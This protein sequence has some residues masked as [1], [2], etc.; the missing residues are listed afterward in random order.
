MRYRYRIERWLSS[1]HHS[2]R[3]CSS[4]D[5]EPL[6]SGPIIGPSF[7]FEQPYT[8]STS[9]TSYFDRATT[10]PSTSQCGSL[11]PSAAASAARLIP[12]YGAPN[13]ELHLPNT[14]S[15]P[16]SPSVHAARRSPCVDSAGVSQFAI[17]DLVQRKHKVIKPSIAEGT[18]TTAGRDYV[19]AIRLSLLSGPN[20]ES[21]PS[22]EGEEV[23]EP[24]QPP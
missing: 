17:L 9:Q 24:Q 11:S 2:D 18:L 5:E 14:I 1:R 8:D 4:R 12:S 20:W 13:V 15:P 21:T 16:S 22:T 23:S 10:C 19:D 6:R 3:A 7:S